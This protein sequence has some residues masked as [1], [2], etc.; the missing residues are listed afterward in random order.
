MFEALCE[1][2]H[3]QGGQCGNQIG[4]TLREVLSARRFNWNIPLS[5][6]LFDADAEWLMDKFDLAAGVLLV[7]LNVFL[8]S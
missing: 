7:T 2:V 3:T 4:A 6:V 8:G 5:Q 1:L